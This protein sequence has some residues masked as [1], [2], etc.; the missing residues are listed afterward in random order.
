MRT[1]HLQLPK[2]F[3]NVSVTTDNKIVADTNDS[4]NWDK[5]SVPLPK[6]KWS[7]QSFF[8]APSMN[9]VV[10]IDKRNYLERLFNL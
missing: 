5:I 7:I 10:L 9:G 1:L 6:G 2:G 8:G 4:A 3:R